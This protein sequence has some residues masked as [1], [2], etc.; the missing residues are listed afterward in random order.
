MKASEL[1]KILQAGIKQFG[2]LEVHQKHPNGVYGVTK[3]PV[4]AHKLTSSTRS[5]WSDY[6]D[7][8]LKGEKVFKI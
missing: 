2:D 1:I 8:K 3:R 4:V 6:Y 5:L 7:E